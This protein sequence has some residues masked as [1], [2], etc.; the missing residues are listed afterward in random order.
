M[1]PCP[2]E[3]ASR[4]IFEL[5][6]SRPNGPM[7]VTW[8]TY[9]PDF[10]QWKCQVSPGRTTTLPG[11]YASD[12]AAIEPF[13]EPD[14]EHAGHH[15]C[16]CGPP[17]ACEA[18][19]RRRR[20]LDP[21]HMDQ[22]R[23]VDRRPR[24]DE[25]KAE[26]PGTASSRCLPG[27]IR[28]AWNNG[29]GLEAWSSAESVC[30]HAPLAGSVCEAVP[31]ISLASNVIAALSTFETGQFFSAS[32]AISTNLVSSRFGTFARRVRADWL[33]RN[34]WPSGSMRDCGL[35]GE[36]SRGIAAGLQ[37]ERER[38]GEATGVRRGDELFGVGTLLVLEA[39]LE[40]I[41]RLCEH[42]GIGGKIAAA[43]ATGPAPNRFRLADH[44]SL[45]RLAPRRALFVGPAISSVV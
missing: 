31:Q 1:R 35:G 29:L 22:A 6:Y 37:P 4:I 40:G 10:A 33:M 21:D 2:S 9:S 44:V 11:G 17:G 39:C 12:P 3:S 14:V 38:H 36:L 41:R 43:G 27:R 20:H 25:P 5:L 42:T 24:R 7:A 34:P 26:R 45:S 30:G 15:A 23:Q 32:L 18:S 8:V 13:A 28:D 16:R 19:A